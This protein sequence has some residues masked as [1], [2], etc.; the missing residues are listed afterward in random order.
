MKPL[1][2]ADELPALFALCKSQCISDEAKRCIYKHM[3]TDDLLD[4]A[5]E[6]L[7]QAMLDVF[8]TWEDGFWLTIPVQTMGSAF[9][10]YGKLNQTRFL[11]RRIASYANS[12]GGTHIY[13][14]RIH[15]WMAARKAARSKS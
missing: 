5:G 10:I 3:D 9:D 8:E 1:W 6:H 7:D 12:L 2:H 14:Q 11:T 4:L 15:D 13:N